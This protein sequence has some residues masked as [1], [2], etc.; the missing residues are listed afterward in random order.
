MIT[1]RQVSVLISG[2]RNAVLFTIITSVREGTLSLHSVRSHSTLFSRNPVRSLEA[3]GESFA[4]IFVFVSQDLSSSVG[5]GLGTLRLGA[6][7][8][9]TGVLAEGSA[10]LASGRAKT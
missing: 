9:K 6:L 8:S 4:V 10:L 7:A 1:L 2:V 5:G 3:V